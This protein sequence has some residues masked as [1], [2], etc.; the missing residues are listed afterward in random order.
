MIILFL[1]LLLLITHA[2]PAFAASIPQ[3]DIVAAYSEEEHRIYGSEKISFTNDGDEPLSE[4]YLFLYPNL[5]LEKDPDID[6]SLYKRAYPVDFNAGEQFIT[7]I[8]DLKGQNLPYFPE[9]FKKRIL[10][11]IRLPTPI[12]PKGT[13]AFLVHFVTVIPEKYGV[14]GYYRDLVTLQG[15]W[16][17][18]LSFFSEGK[19]NFLLP[20]SPSR[21]QIHFTL[22]EH[23]RL[24][25]SVPPEFENEEGSDATFLLR[26]NALPTVSLSI[27]KLTSEAGQVGPVN[28]VYHFLPRDKT[29]A[30]QVLRIAEEAADHFLKQVG[31]LPPTQLQMMESYLYQDLVTSGPN[32]LYVSNKL[33]KVFPLLK[34]FHEASVARGVFLL[35]WQE[36][37]PWEEIWMIEGLADLETAQFIGAKYGG[38][39]SLER[40]LSPISFIPIID[41]ILYSQ[42]LPLRQIYFKEKVAPLINED[43]QFFNHSRPEGTTIFSKLQNL[44]GHETVRRAVEDYKKKIQTGEQ[45]SFRQVLY[46]ISGKKL[47][48]F[49]E[50]WLTSN[51]V[52]DFGIEEIRREKTEEGY[53]TTLKIKKHGEGIEP[54]EILATQ[55]NGS[56]IPLVWEGDRE[57]H[58]EVLITPSRVDIVELDPHRDSSDPNRL[59]NRDPRLWKFLL[60]RVPVPSFNLNTQVLSYEVGLLFQPVYDNTN[61]IGFGFSHSDVGNSTSLQFS[62]I[63]RNNHTA[64]V[65][66]SYQGPQTPKDKPPEEQAGTVHLGYS[67]SY[68]N[69]P[70]L[71]GSVQRLLGRY[72]KFNIALGYDQRFTGGKY[73][74]LVTTT[75]DTRRTFSFSNYHEIATHAMV[76]QSFGTLFENSRFFL[77]GDRGMRGYTPLRFEGD[78]ILLLSAEY[79]FPLYYESDVNLRVA[80]T[81]TL[82]GAIFADVGTVTDS[83]N[84]FRVGD[85]KK[86]I[87]AGIRWYID[88]LGFYPLTF[89][90]DVA[91][92]VGPAIEAEKKPHYYITGGMP[93]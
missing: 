46:G 73:E 55:E 60:D 78:N 67:L 54:I 84:I 61:Q 4:I 43:I 45:I 50:Q 66:L 34:R 63:F 58:Q 52:L 82:Q 53:K 7:S 26:A 83:R 77:G 30:K 88:S 40:W 2:L 37:L 22:N 69:I 85:Y 39:Q 89:R 8:Q 47:D 76:G 12:P 9:L 27:G 35:L 1:P 36:R 11:K 17:P 5:Y 92:P 23:L 21:F 25:A 44:L 28:L 91:I 18:Y 75:I 74:H 33:F 93:F 19:W 10:M 70:L 86:D 31:L 71:V 57:E 79:R 20:P 65:G 51:P 14:F 90:F 62:H 32:L 41:Q 29:Y 80:L 56:K 6:Q 68:P 16:H 38:Q 24:L 48:W 72:P 64:T 15:G 3:Y 59:N 87:G 42:D 81:H 49:F 13:F